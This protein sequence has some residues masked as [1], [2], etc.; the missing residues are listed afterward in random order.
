LQAA[1][2]TLLLIT[3]SVVFASV[4]INYAVQTMEQTTKEIPTL[5]NNNNSGADSNSS[6]AMDQLYS[7][8][9]AAL[10]PS[11]SPTLPP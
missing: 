7:S 6:T 3:A 5:T 10:Q 8:I 9:N 2:A 1:V 4:V 11:P